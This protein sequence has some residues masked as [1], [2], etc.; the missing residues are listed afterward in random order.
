MNVSDLH[1]CLDCPLL[2]PALCH[3]ES[4]HEKCYYI[5]KQEKKTPRIQASYAQPS[6]FQK[7]APF[8]TMFRNS[9]M[10]T[11]DLETRK[12]G[13]GQTVRIGTLVSSPHTQCTWGC[14]CTVV[15][16]FLLF[17]LLFWEPRKKVAVN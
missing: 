14:V 3:V 8:D 11:C 15:S 2:L 5:L 12:A 1:R 10:V 13:L 17:V 9:T 6:C 4:K 7:G 16:F